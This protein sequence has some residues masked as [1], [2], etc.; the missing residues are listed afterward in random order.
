MSKPKSILRTVDLLGSA[1]ASDRE[2]PWI[3]AR[4]SDA[5]NDEFDDG[6]ADFALRGWTVENWTTGGTMT[7]VGDVSWHAGASIGSAEYRSTR[8]GSSIYVQTPIGISM[9]VHK[10]FAAG[11]YCFAAKALPMYQYAGIECKLWAYTS[12]RVP[13]T[14]ERNAY[15]AGH[16]ATG[17][18]TGILQFIHTNGAG[19]QSYNTS[20]NT[21]THADVPH[22]ILVNDL[23]SVNLAAQSAWNSST[24]R[25][26][27]QRQHSG[28]SS[29]ALDVGLQIFTDGP[30]SLPSNGLLRAVCIDWIR[31]DG[32]TP[33]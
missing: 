6:S 29:A 31:R 23:R 32:A 2:C 15:G 11:Q 12:A 14:P 28:A 22:D 21:F 25:S 27:W 4:G 9:L 26:R 24:L 18:G 3:P 17:L 19:T 16:I 30:G 1:G 13:A 7:R 10:T 8:V 20:G 5:W 33:L